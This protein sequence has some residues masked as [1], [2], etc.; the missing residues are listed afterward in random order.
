MRRIIAATSVNH[1]KTR[2]LPAVHAGAVALRGVP[3]SRTAAWCAAGSPREHEHSQ[4]N[5]TLTPTGPDDPF[6]VGT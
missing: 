6:Q 4:D 1:P 2:V 3:N 5:P